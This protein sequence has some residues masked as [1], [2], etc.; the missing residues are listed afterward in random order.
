MLRNGTDL[1]DDTQKN[2][3]TGVT[4]WNNGL[5][6]TAGIVG[7]AVGQL[8]VWLG[9]FVAAALGA[10]T[11][12][13]QLL[14]CTSTV[15]FPAAEEEPWHSTT[16]QEFACEA[17][18]MVLQLQLSDVAP[19]LAPMEFRPL[20]PVEDGDD[21]TIPRDLPTGSVI[22]YNARVLKR[23]GA[24][25]GKVGR[26][27]LQTTWMALDDGLAPRGIKYNLPHEDLGRWSLDGI[28]ERV[29]EGH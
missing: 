22:A 16:D 6:P 27:T 4:R 26:S 11:D 25:S 12:Q 18:A 13:L 14:E 1:R 7:E 8:S 5:A 21:H 24:N 29:R 2:N 10:P 3:I 19:A 15:V 17:T 20:E 23:S 9:D 28:A